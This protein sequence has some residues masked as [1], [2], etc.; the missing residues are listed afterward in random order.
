MTDPDVP[1]PSDPYLRE[2]LHWYDTKPSHA[3]LGLHSTLTF[4]TCVDFMISNTL[5]FIFFCL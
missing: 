3:E 4:L 5:L 2:H 1:G